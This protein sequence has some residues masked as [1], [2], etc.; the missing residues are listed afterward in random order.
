MV[1]F[2]V[3][4]PAYDIFVWFYFSSEPI[5]SD[6]ECEINGWTCW[7]FRVRSD[8]NYKYRKFIHGIF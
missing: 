5:V 2:D 4:F 8:F 7:P 6:I 1:L 3:A